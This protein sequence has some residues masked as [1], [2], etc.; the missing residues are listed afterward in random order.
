VAQLREDIKAGRLKADPGVG[1]IRKHLKV[2][3]ERA[4]RLRDALAAAESDDRE[5]AHA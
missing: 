2:G 1:T 5:A 3:Q 4:T